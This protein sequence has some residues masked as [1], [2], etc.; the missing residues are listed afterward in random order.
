VIWC[1]AHTLW[2]GSTF[3]LVTSIGLVLHHVFGV[4]HGDRR[5]ADRYGAAFETV[6]ADTSIVP[7]LAIAQGRQTLQ[8]QEF[9]RPAYFGVLVFI[10]LLWWAHPW[11]IV[12]TSRVVF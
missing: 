2:I 11:L 6:K 8:W 10:G 7:F 4:W 5:L 12:A 1:I 3:T 9:I